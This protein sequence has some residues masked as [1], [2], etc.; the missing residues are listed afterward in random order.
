MAETP[1]GA[2]DAAIEDAAPV[3]RPAAPDDVAGDVSAAGG[4][5][6]PIDP[7]RGGEADDYRLAWLPLTDLGNAERFRARYGEDFLW[8][9]ALGWLA[10]DGRRYA[11]D[12]ARARLQRAVYDTVRRIKDEAQAIADSDDDFAVKPA[13]KDKGAVMWSDKISAW[14]RASESAARLQCVPNLAACWMTVDGPEDLD[15]D[16]WLINVL[17]GT[18]D[19]RRRDDGDYVR[20][21]P[22]DRAD[23]MTKLAPVTYDPDADCLLPAG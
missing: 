13:G 1:E 3:A 5:S 6:G 10:W 11:R 20:L 8:C 18:L 9:E 16:P 23:R 19:V 7:G 22:H 15:A 14:A 17:N 12:G 4:P 21:R 2:I